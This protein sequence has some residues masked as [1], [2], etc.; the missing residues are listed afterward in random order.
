MTKARSFL[1]AM[2]GVALLA[3]LAHAQEGP[4]PRP[5]EGRPQ[6]PRRERPRPEQALRQLSRGQAGPAQH[7][8]DG[9]HLRIRG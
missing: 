3:C 1:V 9:A 7:L 8:P 4:R 2:V 6:P 5:R